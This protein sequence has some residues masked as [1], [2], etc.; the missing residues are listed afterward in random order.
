MRKMLSL[1]DAATSLKAARVDLNRLYWARAKRDAIMTLEPLHK[2]M[3]LLNFYV[4]IWPQFI[5]DP[6]CRQRWSDSLDLE[7]EKIE[8]YIRQVNAWTEK[9]V[10]KPV[11]CAM[12][13]KKQR[14]L[15]LLPPL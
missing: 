12:P 1:R 4:A 6:A 2:D 10:G 15:G 14:E 8:K 11:R 7:I 9:V 13:K 3:D 5:K